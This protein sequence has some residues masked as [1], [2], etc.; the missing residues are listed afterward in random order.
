LPAKTL[1]SLEKTAAILII[2]SAEVETRNLADALAADYRISAAPNLDEAARRLEKETF[3]ALIYVFLGEGLDLV[4]ILQ[5]LQHLSPATPVIVIGQENDAQLI[6]GAIKA[7]AFDFVTKPYPPEKIRLSVHQA[8]EHRSLK[9]EIDYLR[10]EQDVVYDYD[11]IIAVSPAMRKAIGTIKKLARTDSTILVTGETGTGKSFFSGNIHFNSLRRHKPFIKVNCA[12]IPETL[13]ESELFGHEKGS[14]TGADKTRTGRFEQANG[15]TIFLDEFCELSF[16]LQAKLL[17]AIE[18]KAFERLGGNKTIHSDTRIIA[19]TNRDIE[20]LVREG[21]FREDLYY[22]INVLRIHL[23]PLRER[24]D[25]IEPMAHHLLAK[26]GRSVK[27]K[28]DS[29]EPEVIEMFRKYPW[30]GNIRQLSNTIERAILMEDEMVIRKENISLPKI[31]AVSAA[32]AKPAAL[33]LSPDQEKELISSALED[34]LWI[35][36]DAARQLGITPRALNYRIKKLGITHSRWRK[37]RG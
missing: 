10:R 17:R 37:N 13:L 23:P 24:V 36:K 31:D 14:F 1:S 33:T 7:G 5:S 18:D 16:E 25:C 29:F 30:P 28:I 11:R 34:N 19:A 2:G 21:K 32:K 26:L 3:S 22:R 15:G 6:V 27:K 9:N 20:S 35:Q 8:L 4:H 12:N